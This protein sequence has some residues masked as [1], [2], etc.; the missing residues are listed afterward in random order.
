MT[1]NSKTEITIETHRTLVV[2]RRPNFVTARCAACAVDVAFASPEDAA[3]L[4]GVGA[5]EIYRAVEE[6]Q[7]HFIETG[8]RQLRVCMTSLLG[9]GGTE[10][11]RTRLIEAPERDGPSQAAEPPAAVAEKAMKVV[12]PD[13]STSRKRI[14]TLTAEA[15]DLLLS[16][17]DPD[18]DTA[19]TRYELIRA[20]LM[21]YLECRGCA[22]PEEL[23]DETINRVAR[24][25]H[26]G[27]QIWTA[28]PGSYFY[29]VARNVLR[30]YWTAPERDFAHLESLPP[31]AHPSGD[32]R[33]QQ[34]AE[35]E[36]SD[37]EA[38]LDSLGACLEQLPA[39]SRDLI[40]EY[41]RGERAQR[42]LSRKQM[43]ERL[44]IPANALRIRVHRIRERLERSFN[45]YVRH[46]HVL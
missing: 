13:G 23:A 37:V 6:G 14:W 29:G 20:K 7:L 28:E 26:E 10:T 1:K 18:R 46:P 30:E 16:R 42:I 17:L 41:Y 4:T 44:G 2:R 19:A 9:A 35:C 5:R 3:R 22:S 12:N 43:A 38:Q 40:L 15:F 21:K 39:D 45:E 36:R 33:K 34:E 32:L 24:R 8:N 27:K 31:A 25:L 11:G